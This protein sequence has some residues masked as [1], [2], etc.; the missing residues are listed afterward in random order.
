MQ[1]ATTT[2]GAFIE[3]IKTFLEGSQTRKREQSFEDEVLNIETKQ[4]EGLL[5]R[6]EDAIQHLAISLEESVK[7]VECASEQICKITMEKLNSFAIAAEGVSS[8]VSIAIE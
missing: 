3:S 4:V 6:M 1:D 2:P 5:S 8:C 7:A